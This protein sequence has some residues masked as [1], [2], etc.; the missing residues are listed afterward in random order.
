MPRLTRN[1]HSNAGAGWGFAT[2]L[3]GAV[4]LLIS[5]AVYAQSRP[6]LPNEPV[7][8][9]NT[10]AQFYRGLNVA[11]VK[12]LDGVGH[13][14]N[15]TKGL[16]GQGGKD[17]DVEALDGLRVGTHVAIHYSLTGENASIQEIDMPDG[18]G[19]L[20]ITE[21][22]LT[23][24]DRGRKEITVR[25]TNGHTETL[26]MTSPP[27]TVDEGILDDSRRASARI[28]VYYADESGRKVGHYFTMRQ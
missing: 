20:T 14:Y 28:V 1:V 15:F 5:T 6:P 3:A 25:F 17:P 12:T 7:A 16:F 2:V 11:L 22:V 27:A 10:T 13:V 18:D 24:I 21:A 19:G 23:N 4:V 9:E 8:T 26:A